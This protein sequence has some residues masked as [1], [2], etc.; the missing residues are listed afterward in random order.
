MTKVHKGRSQAEV[1]A[2]ALA[3]AER[4]CELA[5]GGI[6]PL[7]REYE[8]QRG[9]APTVAMLASYGVRY[10]DVVKLAGLRMLSGADRKRIREARLVPDDLEAEIQAAFAAQ[11]ETAIDLAEWPMKAIPTRV[12]VRE[13]PLENG[14]VYRVTRCYA[15]IR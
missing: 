1:N 9:D 7:Q 14:G 15:S 13:Y 3:A 2:L 6:A 12:E 10:R 4:L 5:A 8:A 11:A